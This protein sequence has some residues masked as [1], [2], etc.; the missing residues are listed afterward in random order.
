MLVEISWFI[1]LPIYKELHYWIKQRE[2][3]HLNKN[4][5]MT[6]VV[7]FIAIL[8]VFVPWQSRIE[9]PALLTVKE[10][11]ELFMPFAAKLNKIR[12]TEGQIVKKGFAR[13][14]Q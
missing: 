4:S 14:I 11:T 3:M 1:L 5:L 2:Q 8:V 13:K 9:A 10:H 6:L 12:V 7:L